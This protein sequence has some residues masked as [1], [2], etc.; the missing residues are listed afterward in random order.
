[1]K[2]ITSDDVKALAKTMFVPEIVNAFVGACTT[3]LRDTMQWLTD[4]GVKAT[5]PTVKA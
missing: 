4:S 3:P 1:M 5:L 2:S